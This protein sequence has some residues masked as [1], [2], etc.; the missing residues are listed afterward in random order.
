MPQLLPCDS[1]R[2]ITHRLIIEP[3]D[4]NELKNIEIKSKSRISLQFF[5]VKYAR[6]D[7][8]IF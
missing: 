6:T 8:R 1:I 4:E 3:H 2:C 5:S 7:F